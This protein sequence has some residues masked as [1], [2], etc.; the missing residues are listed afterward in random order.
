MIAF[1]VILGIIFLMLFISGL[2]ERNLDREDKIQAKVQIKWDNLKRIFEE[3]QKDLNNK[4]VAF[5]NKVR[6][7]EEELENQ[8]NRLREIQKDLE[9]QSQFQI[10]QIAKLEQLIKDR[11]QCYPQLASVMADILTVHY[12]EVAQLLCTKKNP[13]KIEATR[14]REL[15]KETKK[16]I[17]EKKIYE[18]QINYL[19]SLFPDIDKYFDIDYEL[20]PDIESIEDN[21]DVVS[22]YI[23]PEEYRTLSVS[24]RNQLALDNYIAR[25]KSKW[26]I[27][28]DFE[29]YTGHFYKNKG[30]HIEYNGIIKRLEDMGRDIIASKDTER[31]IIQCKNWSKEKLIHENHIFQL[32]G[33]V[34]YAKIEN[35]DFDVKGVFITTI[36]LSKT[37]RAVA[38]YLEIEVIEEFPMGDFPRIKCNINKATGEK[39]Y[40]LPFDQQYDTAKIESEGEFFAFTVAEAEQKGF[41]R[42]WRHHHN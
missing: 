41:R 30:Y 33:T 24:E 40:H 1:F 39:I 2:I 23:T 7:T 15:R 19:R 6:N 20:N 37:A 42:A 9:M 8:R 5:E 11:C 38:K 21:F 14:I 25:K 18:Y 27:G 13:A 16:I 10:D 36:K 32:Y 12:E 22:N 31:L 17:Q 3:D 26:Q 28:R 4:K 35:P 29:L 34:V